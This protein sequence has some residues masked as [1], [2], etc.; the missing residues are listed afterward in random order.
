MVVDVIE[1][2]ETDSANCLLSHHRLVQDP[3]Q[4]VGDDGGRMFYSLTDWDK[5]LHLEKKSFEY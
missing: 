3:A 5:L 4:D 1:K 2:I